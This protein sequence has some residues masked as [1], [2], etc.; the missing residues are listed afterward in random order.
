MYVHHGGTAKYFGPLRGRGQETKLLCYL[1]ST[2]FKLVDRHIVYDRFLAF[3]F[4]SLLLLVGVSYSYLIDFIYFSGSIFS[5]RPDIVRIISQ[6]M[7][8]RRWMKMAVSPT[9]KNDVTLPGS[10][11][12]LISGLLFPFIGTLF[13]NVLTFMGFLFSSGTL[14]TF[15]PGFLTSSAQFSS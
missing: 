14:T 6:S 15:L 2:C 13:F 7:R 9:K 11:I 8:Q 5:R 1:A 4:A 12:A 3:F 10:L